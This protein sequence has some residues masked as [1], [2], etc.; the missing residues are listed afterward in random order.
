MEG[1]HEPY[2]HAPLLFPA[3]P[4]HRTRSHVTAP[5]RHRCGSSSYADVLVDRM[6]QRRRDRQRPISSSTSGSPRLSAGNRF[7]T[8]QSWVTSSITAGTHQITRV[9]AHTNIPRTRPT[10]MPPSPTLTLIPVIILW[11]VPITV[12]K[13]TVQMKSRPLRLLLDG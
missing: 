5:N 6:R 13:A 3:H 8:P 4:S 2:H 9:A 11:S 10:R 7:I 12:S 1:T